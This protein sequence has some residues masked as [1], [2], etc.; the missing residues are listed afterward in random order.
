[1]VEARFANESDDAVPADRYVLLVDNIMNS[2][3]LWP[4]EYKFTS[5]DRE[6]RKLSERRVT[7]GKPDS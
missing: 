6:G 3:Y 2:L 1:V 5:R 7:V 4:G